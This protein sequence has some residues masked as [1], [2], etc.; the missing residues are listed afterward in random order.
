MLIVD[1]QNFYFPGDGPGLVNAEQAS[2]TAKEI[3]QVFR[4]KKLLVVH[5]RHK[6]LKGSEIHKNV[7]PLPNEKVIMK[8]EVNSFHR[9]DLLEYLKVNN[10][11]RLVII[12]MQTQMCLEAAVRAAH[13]HGFECIVIQEAC[14]TRDLRF[15][16]KVVKAEDVQASTLATISDGGY[17]KVI[18][19]SVFKETPD[20]YLFQKSD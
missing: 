9:T 16:G 19:M 11:T 6:S 17:G 2:L 14:A 8:E 13:D 15:G 1:I 20:K 3:L 10:I 18:E 5:V 4:D 12:G 7:E